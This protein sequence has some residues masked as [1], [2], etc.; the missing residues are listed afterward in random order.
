MH[1]CHRRQTHH[2]PYLIHRR[3]LHH[4]L[5]LLL[6]VRDTITVMTISH[7]SRHGLGYATKLA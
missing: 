7:V 2:Y 6:T 3:H 4:Q 5:S 1:S